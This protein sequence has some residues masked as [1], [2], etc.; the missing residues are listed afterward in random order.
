MKNRQ[1]MT[2]NQAKEKI[3]MQEQAQSRRALSTQSAELTLRNMQ[4]ADLQAAIDETVK[5]FSERPKHRYIPT[6]AREYRDAA[7][8]AAWRH[9][10]EH[11]GN[12]NYPNEARRKGMSGS[13]LLDVAINSDGVVVSVDVRRSS[14]HKLLDDAAIRIV[15]LASPFAPFTEEMK[16]DTDI[17]HITRTWEFLN[18]QGFST[19]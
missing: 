13:L 19:R 17:L 4:L 15:R 5:T 12:L 6:R 14:G 9:T 16:K 3:Q 18:D 2:Q 11:V 7:Y 8:L 10:I 1:V